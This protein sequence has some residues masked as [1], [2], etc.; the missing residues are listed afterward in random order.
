M[1]KVITRSEVVEQESVSGLTQV[2]KWFVL[3]LG[4]L[5]LAY[6]FKFIPNHQISLGLMIVA[7]AGALVSLGMTGWAFLQMKKV[8]DLAHITVNCPYCDF[9][10]QFLEQPTDDYDCEGCH[11][12]VQYRNGQ[13]VPIKTVTCQ[14][15]KTVHKVPVTATKF[16]CD[17]C[18]RGVKL[19]DDPREVVAERSELLQN[20]DVLLTDAGRKRTEVAMALESILICNLA[21]ARRQMENLPL[22]VVRNVPERKADAVRG[23]LRE[24]GA[25]AVVRPTEDQT[26]PRR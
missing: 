22:T 14:S 1:P 19:T 20:Y 21:E 16:I 2:I 24:L 17:R 12:R 7:F 18:N 15:C 4:C 25:T 8:R 13:P 23:R 3:L 9:P 11:R 10:M 26:V 6:L 5:F